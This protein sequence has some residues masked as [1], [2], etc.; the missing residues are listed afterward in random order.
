MY[1]I[2]A[3]GWTNGKYCLWKHVGTRECA[4]KWAQYYRET[5]EGKPYPN[6]KG[7]FKCKNFRVI[8]VN[9]PRRNRS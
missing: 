3:D 7:Y 4:E 8:K 5:Y 6:G 2:L 1:N 9:K